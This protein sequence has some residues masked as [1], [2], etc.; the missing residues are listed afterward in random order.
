M[1]VGL[2]LIRS[3]YYTVVSNE[4]RLLRGKRKRL[5]LRCCHRLCCLPLLRNDGKL[6]HTVE[7]GLERKWL[8]LKTQSYVPSNKYLEG[9]NGVTV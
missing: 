6:D 4:L 5:H 2:E 8:I 1:R 9:L 3:L 7:L